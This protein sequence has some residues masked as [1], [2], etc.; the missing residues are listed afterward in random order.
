MTD[1]EQI[2]YTEE[3]CPYCDSVVELP[4]FKGIYECP[5]CK[6]LIVC[7]SM[8]QEQSC[9]DCKYTLLTQSKDQLSRKMQECESLK[10]QLDF[11][12][13]Q[14][15]CFKIQKRLDK[16][17]YKHDFE[18]LS[19]WKLND[20]NMQLSVLTKIKDILEHHI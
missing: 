10:S 9:N 18:D 11:E 8:C 1:K 4:P 20:V 6:E 19:S 14:K 15:E 5:E 3:T 7:C 12:A 2:I 13:Q 17:Q 16:L